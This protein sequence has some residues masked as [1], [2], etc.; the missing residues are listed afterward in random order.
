[1]TNENILKKIIFKLVRNIELTNEENNL[2]EEI[3][4]NK[5]E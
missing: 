4:N 3:V 1:M 5:L 2:V